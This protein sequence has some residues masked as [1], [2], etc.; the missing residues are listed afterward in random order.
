M[1][2]ELGPQTG[3]T[4]FDSAFRRWVRGIDSDADV[5][6][7]RQKW[8]TTVRRILFRLGNQLAAQA[9]SRAIVGRDITRRNPK[10][11]AST[12]THYCVALAEIWYR[13]R[14]NKLIPEVP[15]EGENE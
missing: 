6:E 7:V 1:D 10:T 8:S 9:S 4:A 13:G 15:N 2:R 11:G 14:I 3:Y 5:E 12:T